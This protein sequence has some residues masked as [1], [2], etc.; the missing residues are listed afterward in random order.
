MGLVLYGGMGLHPARE[1][2]NPPEDALAL[3][4]SLS[5]KTWKGTNDQGTQVKGSQKSDQRG[6]GFA[7]RQLLPRM[8]C[9]LARGAGR[10]TFEEMIS[11]L[12][13]QKVID[14]SLLVGG[15]LRIPASLFL[16]SFLITRTRSSHRVG[17]GLKQYCQSL[18]NMLYRQEQQSGKVGR[19]VLKT[20]GEYQ[21]LS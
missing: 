21:H 10:S 8:L 13:I 19:G 2:V 15:H 18:C 12:N 16:R 11:A 3:S 17:V 4:V 20:A 6:F 14:P 9:G 7:D 1:A 5:A